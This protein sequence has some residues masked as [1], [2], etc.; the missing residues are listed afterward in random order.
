MKHKREGSILT[1]PK[2]VEDLIRIKEK[3]TSLKSKTSQDQIFH[4]SEDHFFHFLEGLPQ[5]IRTNVFSELIV[6]MY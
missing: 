2:T 1:Y 5:N 4:F 6:W 3:E